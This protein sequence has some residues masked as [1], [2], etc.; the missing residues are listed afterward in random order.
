MG[1]IYA[2][3]SIIPNGALINN[4]C[5]I[6][7]STKP[8]TRPDGS[9]LV[10]GDVWY[11]SDEG[12]H[13]RWNGVLW[14]NSVEHQ[15]KFNLLHPTNLAASIDNSPYGDRGVLF[16]DLFLIMLYQSGSLDTSNRGIYNLTLNNYNGG[17]LLIRDGLIDTEL[18]KPVPTTANTW[19]SNKI[20]VNTYVPASSFFA[21]ATGGITIQAG[22][23][24]RFTAKSVTGTPS[25]LISGSLKYRFA[26]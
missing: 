5:H 13:W 8:T 11:K 9:A 24:I 15:I 6:Y 12:M 7:Q 2:P 10:V 18:L 4:V 1:M 20:N 26:Q 14:V 19:S 17:A 3:P 21:A 25:F 23:A 16:T 22:N